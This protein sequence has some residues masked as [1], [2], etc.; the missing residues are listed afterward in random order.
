MPVHGNMA[1]QHNSPLGANVPQVARAE[2][3]PAEPLPILGQV[4]AG[5]GGESLDGQSPAEVACLHMHTFP[6]RV[7]CQQ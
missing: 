6:V 1:C 7:F 4:L 3:A 2:L 5:L